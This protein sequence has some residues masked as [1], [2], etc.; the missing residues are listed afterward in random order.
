MNLKRHLDWVGGLLCGVAA[1]A[2]LASDVRTAWEGVLFAALI[3]LGYVLP[4]AVRRAVPNGLW[5]G[6][7][8]ALL[9]FEGAR[10]WQS[11]ANV[12][13]Y[14]FE[15]VRWLLVVKVWGRRSGRDELQILLLSFFVL[16]GGTV[17]TF[18][19]IIAPLLLVYVTL[20]PIGLYLASA[21]ATKSEEELA[22]GGPLIP[23]RIYKLALLSGA[24]IFLGGGIIFF[25]LPRLSAA[26]VEFNFI[27]GAGGNRFPLGVDLRQQGLLSPNSRVVFRVSIDPPLEHAPLWRVQSLGRFDGTRWSRLETRSSEL[28]RAAPGVFAGDLDA[29][30]TRPLVQIFDF[31]LAPLE[32]PALVTPSFRSLGPVDTLAVRGPFSEIST[33]YAGELFF[34]RSETRRSRLL[35]MTYEVAYL[36]PAAGSASP[37]QWMSPALKRRHTQ[38]PVLLS[39]EVETL[40][41]ELAR[42][43]DSEGTGRPINRILAVEDYLTENYTYSLERRASGSPDPVASFLFEE[44]TGHCEYFAS[45]A[46]VLLRAQGIPARVVTGFASGQYDAAAGTWTV[47]ESDAHSWVEAWDEQ[48]G[49]VS[50]DPSPRDLAAE[51]ARVN[52]WLL[53]YQDLKQQAELWWYDWVLRYSLAEQLGIVSKVASELPKMTG[54]NSGA[55]PKLGKRL[56]PEQV[57]WAVGTLVIGVGLLLGLGVFRRRRVDENTAA[58]SALAPLLEPLQREARRWGIESG[59]QRTPLEVADEL[60]HRAGGAP[61]KAL[62]E[63][64][65]HYNEARYS[66]RVDPREAGRELKRDW[67]NVGAALKRS[68]TA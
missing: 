2:Y 18:S 55:L 65:S 58:R 33:S 9:L 19:Y 61:G 63:W 51:H 68:R 22:R 50:I 43:A 17:F 47:R 7:L 10:T 8:L 52:Q 62:L 42:E 24:L 46:A 13:F 35:P 27:D 39:P 20:A 1:L 29:I 15:F 38:L 30:E 31:D 60:A 54:G 25:S 36:A 16:L 48:E 21:A 41:R 14:L 37:H 44:K 45:A 49:W 4:G 57:M 59:E 23:L 56:P 66:G 67:K 6:A 11:P 40:A 32:I 34:E 53:A 12:V 28:P 64:V 26:I 3:V 5:T